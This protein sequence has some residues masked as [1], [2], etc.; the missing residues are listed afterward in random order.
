VEHIRAGSVATENLR[1]A[2]ELT[3]LVVAAN[4]AA[5]RGITV[6]YRAAA[7]ASSHTAFSPSTSS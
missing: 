2:V 3:R 1:A 4:E 7:A 5:E 6:D